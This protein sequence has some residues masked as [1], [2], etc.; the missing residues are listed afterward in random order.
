MLLAYC[1]QKESVMAQI[2]IIDDETIIRDLLRQALEYV[3]YDVIEACNGREGLRCCRGALPHLV[4]TD[5]AMPEQDGFELIAQLRRE[6]PTTAI[7]AMSGSAPQELERAK[8]LGAACTV[9][10]PFDL[11]AMTDMVHQLVQVG[12]P[13]AAD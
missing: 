11:W 5:L 7:I 13:A 1:F 8:Q 3:G 6:F 10:K 9:R 12:V 2:L 4:I